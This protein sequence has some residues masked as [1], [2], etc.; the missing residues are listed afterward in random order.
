MERE[1]GRE[2]EREREER[3]REREGGREREG[4]RERERERGRERE[5]ER[6]REREREKIYIHLF[7]R[8]IWYQEDPSA[9]E[10]EPPTP[11]YGT[12]RS[13]KEE[14]RSKE[15]AKSSSEARVLLGSLTITSTTVFLPSPHPQSYEEG[16]E[17][18]S[19]FKK[20]KGG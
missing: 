10:E 3:E 14:K 20:C 8:K 1:R 13:W 11:Q 16:I 4:E 7:F 17:E 12:Q 2:R 18:H 19:E 5:G 9:K 6:E 15:R